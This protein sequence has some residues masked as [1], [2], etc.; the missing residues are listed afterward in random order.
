MRGTRV[1][2]PAVFLVPKFTYHDV[3]QLNR[4]IKSRSV[5]DRFID[6]E[7]ADRHKGIIIEVSEQFGLAV[8][9]SMQQETVAEHL[10]EDEFDR[11]IH[12]VDTCGR[13]E[14]FDRLGESRKRQAVPCGDDFFVTEGFDAFLTLGEKFLLRI[15]DE[16]V[17][18]RAIL[19]EQLT[20]LFDRQY[21]MKNIF[22]F[23]IS[24]IA[25]IINAAENLAV[26]CPDQTADF[27]GCPNKEFPF[28]S[29]AVGILG[30]MEST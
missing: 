26:L 22:L 25:D 3:G 30:R 13:I 29:F 9:V 23:E 12:R 21:R 16:R 11:S 8:F 2:K 1:K 15:G 5:E 27:V 6:I 4:S 10:S 18:L 24:L 7:Q 17:D 28:Y 14:G 19:A 20:R